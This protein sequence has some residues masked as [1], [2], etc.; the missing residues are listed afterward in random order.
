MTTLTATKIVI[1]DYIDA[2]DIYWKY[3][4]TVSLDE[5]HHCRYV[6][7]LSLKGVNSDDLLVEASEELISEIEQVALQKAIDTIDTG[8]FDQT[9]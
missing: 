3:E 4:A 5:N 6:D 9:E 1:G 8:D 2:S 7:I